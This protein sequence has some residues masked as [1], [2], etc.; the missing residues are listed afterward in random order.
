MHFIEGARRARLR[1]QERDATIAQC[2][3]LCTARPKQRRAAVTGTAI[4]SRDAVLDV[5]SHLS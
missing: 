2:L 1:D 4:A 5:A 3:G